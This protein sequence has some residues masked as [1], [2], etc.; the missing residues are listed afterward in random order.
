LWPPYEI[1]QAIIFLPCGFYLLLSF[2]FLLLFYSPNLSS[3]KI[4]N[5]KVMQKIAICASSHNFVGLYLRDEGMY[6][7]SERS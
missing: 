7:Q 2:F 5:A 3:L 6:R 4:Q 1:G